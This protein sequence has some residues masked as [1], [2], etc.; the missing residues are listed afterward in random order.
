MTDADTDELHLPPGPLQSFLHVDDSC[1][2]NHG[3]HSLLFL[4]LQ[5]P[6]FRAVLPALPAI[7]YFLRPVSSWGIV[8]GLCQLRNSP[9]FVSLI[10]HLEANGL[11]PRCNVRHL[12]AWYVIEMCSMFMVLAN[13]DRRFVCD[14]YIHD[15]AAPQGTW[16]R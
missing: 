13:F 7:H 4:R 14:V 3:S 6:W 11:L 2:V 10:R 12:V 15:G 16:C 9:C 1:L 8:R 5:P